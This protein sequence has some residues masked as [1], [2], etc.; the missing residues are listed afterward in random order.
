[1]EDIKYKKNKSSIIRVIIS[2]YDMTG[3][4][5]IKVLYQK[6][7]GVDTFNLKTIINL[8]SGNL[9]IISCK[10][11]EREKYRYEL[12]CKV[13]TNTITVTK[14]D[15]VLKKEIRKYFLELSLKDEKKDTIVAKVTDLL[16][17][18]DKIEGERNHLRKLS[19]STERKLLSKTLCKNYSEISK[20]PIEEIDSIKIY[21]IKRFLNYRSNFL[22]YFALINDFLCAG[23][24]E[25][26]INEVRLI[27]DKEDTP[28]LENR[29][30]K[31][32]D[33]IFDKLS[34]DIEN[35][36]NQ[37]EK[38][39]KKYKTSLEE[40]KAETLEKNKTFYIDTIKTKIIN[41]ENKITELSLYNSKESLKE[42]LIKIIS[43][44]TNLRHSLMHYDYKSFE[45][46]F[47]NIENEELKNL[48]DLNLFKSIRMSDEFKT[49]NR[50]NYL[51]GTESFTIVKKH[52][53]L[54][55][56]YTYYNNLC[57]K[58]NGFNAF[59]NSFFITDGIE[60]T[61]FKNSIIL[62]FEKEMEEYKKSIEYYK[63]KIP[64]EKNKSKKEK[65]K[66]K[67]DLLQFELRNMKEHKNLLKQIYFFD[68]HN[69]TKY[70]ELYS[71]R[72]NLIEQYNLQINGVKD[73]T[74]INHINTKLLS[75]KNKMDKITKQNSLYRL[76]YKLKI[77]YSFLML[78]FDGDVSKFKN[79]FDST[80]LEKR[81]KY[82]DKKEE[83]LNYTAPK[84]KFN[85]AKLE[86]ELQKIQ[87]T[88]EMGADYLNVSSENNLFKF[89]ILTYIMLPVEFKG[90]FL[91]FVKNHYYNI[92]N[93]DFIDENLLDEN[94]VD[95]NKLNEKLEN[96]KDSSFFNKIRLFEKNIKKYEIVKYSISTQENM[97]E[98]FKQLNLD[99]PYLDY[100]STD[101]IGIFNKNMIL[102]I[103]KYYQNVFKL[104]NDIEIHA[105]LAL[106]NKKQQNLEYAIYCCSED[107]KLNYNELLKTFNKKTYQNLSFIRNKIAHL[108]YKE[109][110]SDLFN[111]EL[112]LNTK[113]RCLIE[114]SQNNK[115]DKIDLGMNFIND[116]YMKK[117]RFIF[118]QR[119]LRDL[120]VPSKE[121]IID[122][123]RKQQN[124]SNNELLKKYE[125]SRTNIK[126]IFNKATILKKIFD[127]EDFV[128]NHK[129]Y[130]NKI[131]YNGEKI[132]NVYA[133][134]KNEIDKI[135]LKDSSN[136][137]GVY[138]ESVIRLLKNE[139]INRFMHKE[140]K[141]VNINVYDAT[142][143]KTI[144]FTKIIVENQVITKCSDEDFKEEQYYS[145]KFTEEA[146]ELEILPK[147]KFEKN[148]LKK[149]YKTKIYLNTG[150]LFKK[151]IIFGK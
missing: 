88:S 116:Y 105:L 145:C 10:P 73:V 126:D 29:I 101:E 132:S 131:L 35:K 123:K 144:I 120:N 51:D 13:K 31:I 39:I 2:N 67:I 108:N 42:D 118:N 99:I 48:L 38:R 34:K 9:E 23:I 125:L 121:K 53:N 33:Y 122:G 93:V 111:N 77:A 140:E 146:K 62:H 36:K 119:R 24:K 134:N 18:P 151:K 45:N 75:L 92:K 129:N 47:E 113:V 70:K 112:D 91:G 95:N 148:P 52:Q 85:F 79:E 19:S 107:N 61:N 1:M 110:F 102:P 124:D 72:K 22:I 28:F 16:K 84:N 65:L 46:L 30:E 3:I 41:L 55:K 137:M 90:D 50:T 56:L 76:K 63:I 133:I 98:Y 27:Q 49:K 74:A 12:N 142:L 147:S 25:D 78:E 117:T 58:K 89:Y 40:L 17:A 127:G 100:K 71:E 57:D 106:A 109:L 6:Q 136:L 8:E 81:V 43:I 86:E 141:I 66:E 104:C 139:I 37:F 94:E 114:F 68:I 130:F 14:K 5:E 64:N 150:Y 80:N 26:N 59:I 135:F 96:L 15:K 115:F 44:F 143:K 149:D 7:G 83:Y 11:K 87:S 128:Q 54:K 4:K 32:T 103:F 69:S 138:K 20:T 21:K 60:N 97:K 82:L